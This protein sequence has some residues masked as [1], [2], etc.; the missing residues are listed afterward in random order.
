MLAMAVVDVLDLPDQPT[1]TAA[2]D[3]GQRLEIFDYA[4]ASTLEPAES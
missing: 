3:P 4:V 1:A 2:E